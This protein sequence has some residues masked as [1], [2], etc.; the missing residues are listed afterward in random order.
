LRSS[1]YENDLNYI[2]YDKKD[3]Q[4]YIIIKLLKLDKFHNNLITLLKRDYKDKDF[5]SGVYF[6]EYYAI[7]SKWMN[8]YLELYNYEKIKRSYERIDNRDKMLEDDI[9]KIFK[10]KRIQAQPG[11]KDQR[12][13]NLDSIDF[14]VKKDNIPKNIYTD[15][16]SGKVINYFYDFVLLSKE[17]YDKIKVNLA[18]KKEI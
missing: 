9:C 8:N 15:Y 18:K 16:Y 10:D 14:S 11:E 12:I 2:I 4:K 17:I 5:K 13:Y 7:N 1:F 6:K 3:I